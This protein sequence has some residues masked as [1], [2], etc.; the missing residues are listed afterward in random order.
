MP[1]STLQ[2][3]KAANSDLIRKLLDAVVLIAPMSA[4]IPAAFTMGA[5]ATLQAMP[6]EYES[7]GWLTKD[8][9]LTFSRETEMAEVTSHG[10]TEPT[11]RDIT[12]D[13]SGLQ[14]TAQETKK[15]TLELY[16]NVD[17]SSVTPTAITGELSF[18]RS[19]QPVTR[20]RR[21]V[22]IG[23]DG[24]GDDTFYNIIVMPRAMISEV[25]ESTFSDENER[26]F[27]LT[28]NATPD[29]ILGFSYREILAGPGAKSRMEAMGFPAVPTA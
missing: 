15:T 13:V 16:N 28:F 20:Y 10:S 24:D 27:P 19:I 29:P 1:D 14:I 23:Q 4:A 17:L 11:R 8:D 18:N 26:V 6:T 5:S 9:A 3:M 22:V 7:I 21:L 12:S 25:G 2:A